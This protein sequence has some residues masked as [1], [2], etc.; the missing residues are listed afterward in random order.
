M[1]LKKFATATVA[2][3]LLV[4]FSSQPMLAYQEDV[5]LKQGMRGVAVT[6]LQ[7]ELKALGLFN[8]EPTGYFG[9]MTRSSLVR[10]QQSQGLRPDGVAGPSTFAQFKALKTSDLTI[11][12]A[13]LSR[14]RKPVQTLGESLAMTYSAGPIQLLSWFDE[15]S[16]VLKSGDVAT[17]LDIETGYR[18]SITRTGGT[19]HA[20]VETTTAFDTELLRMVA[21]GSWNWTRR[22]VIVEIDGQR[23]AASMTCRPHAGLDNKPAREVV[24]NRSGGYGRGVNYDSVKGND[25]DGHIDI[26]FKNSRTH[27]NNKV[28]KQHQNAIQVAY[29]SNM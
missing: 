19:N 29:K 6:E 9:Q 17:V 10:F 11:A 26:H 1:H 28:D 7:S 21:G 8:E 4:A 14:G 3:L 24:S 12:D 18:F 15:A 27:V 22:P 25:M 20:D 23:I 5:L 16:K 13:T 2:G